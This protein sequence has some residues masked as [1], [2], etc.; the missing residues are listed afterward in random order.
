MTS[1][2][3]TSFEDHLQKWIGKS[4][5]I[6]LA[7]INN[8]TNV[9]T[10]STEKKIVPLLLYVLNGNTPFANLTNRDQFLVLLMTKTEVPEFLENK[11]NNIPGRSMHL[12]VDRKLK[13]IKLGDKILHPSYINHRTLGKFFDSGVLDSDC[14]SSHRQLQANITQSTVDNQ[15]KSIGEIKQKIEEIE[16][17]PDEQSDP[18]YIKPEPEAQ[19]QPESQP[20]PTQAT[21]DKRSYRF[22]PFVN[23]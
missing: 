4:N 12:S 10:G 17:Q 15:R 3:R 11:I 22:T 14:G 9:S 13:F 1:P 20:E 6:N 23:L 5:N 18:F 19:S 16:D 8:F 7:N 2:R 21:K